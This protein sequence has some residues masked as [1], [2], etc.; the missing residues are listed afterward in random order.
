MKQVWKLSAA[1]RI[2]AKPITL[3]HLSSFLESS[4]NYR[5]TREFNAQSQYSKPSIFQPIVG[6]FSHPPSPFDALARENLNRKVTILRDEL[7]RVAQDSDGVHRILEENLEPL[8][9]KYPEGVAFVELLCQLGLRRQL[10]LEVIN[11]RRKSSDGGTPMTKIEYTKSIKIAGKAGNIDLSIELF[12][13]AASKGL[14]TT[15]TYNALMSAFMFNGLADKCQSTFHDMK[16]DA[17]CVPTIVTYNI[18]ICVFGRLLLIDRMEAAFTEIYDLNIAPNI[19]TY[20]SLIAGYVT[21][22]MWDRMEKTFHMLQS[23]LVKPDIETYL[24]MLR[25]YAHSGNLEKMEQT[26]LLVKNHVNEK[27]ISLIRCMICAYCRSSAANRVEKIEA[28]LKLIP[29]EDYKP[30]LN[31]FLIRL[32]A[33]EDWLEEMEN[34]IN[35]AFEH[36]TSVLSHRVMK[37]IIAT[38]F[39]CNALDRL[40]NF[41]KRAE[42]AGWRICRSLYHCKMVMYSSH[43]RL[44][45]MES[46]L[47]EMGNFNLD[48]TKKTFWIM[49]KAYLRC[50]QRSKVEK[51]LGLMFKHGYEIPL[52]A[53]LS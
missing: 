21:A 26:Y 47:S 38:Y 27:Q 37:C 51:I 14:K 17:T 34:S 41:V 48:H 30:W 29:E 31:V 44:E 9:R 25:G 43:E 2:T 19:R 12:D 22:W 24:L 39:R 16:R 1:R 5:C 49:Y 15:A 42:C 50:G 40:S 35:E 36:G 28:L 11:W 33:Q 53:F 7:V 10:L 32:Y 20:N 13:E 23:S 45:D 6:L 8:F 52:S 3:H 4:E 18:L 46:V